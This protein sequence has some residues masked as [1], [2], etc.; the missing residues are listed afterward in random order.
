MPPQAKKATQASP[1]FGLTLMTSGSGESPPTRISV[2][3]QL[4]DGGNS[5]LTSTSYEGGNPSSRS[6]AAIC[7]II[8]VRSSILVVSAPQRAA[9][10]QAVPI[11][12]GLPG[13]HSFEGPCA[14]LPTST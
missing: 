6:S 8:D 7:R 3:P 9:F 11:A 1:A 12:S 13:I 14:L 5:G 4:P 2:T 10:V